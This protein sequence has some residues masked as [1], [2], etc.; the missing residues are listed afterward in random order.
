[1]VALFCHFLRGVSSGYA[2]VNIKPFSLT[3]LNIEEVLLN[4]VLILIEECV[5]LRSV[6]LA[7]A[8]GGEVI[9]KE[10]S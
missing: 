9:G 10:S 1:M 2:G 8:L 3:I 5:H 4:L 6:L 7:C